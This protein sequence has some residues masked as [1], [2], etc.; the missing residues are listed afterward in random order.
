MI[1]KVT[2]LPV[3]FLTSV[4]KIMIVLGM[5]ISCTVQQT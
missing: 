1:L 5:F 3:D 4:G 2:L